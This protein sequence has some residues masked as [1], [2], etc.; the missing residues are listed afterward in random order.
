MPL[1]IPRHRRLVDPD[2]CRNIDLDLTLSMHDLTPGQGQASPLGLGEH[3]FRLVVLPKAELAACTYRPYALTTSLRH[4]YF[5][6]RFGAYGDQ[7]QLYS[8]E[9]ASQFDQS[10]KGRRFVKMQ[11]AYYDSKGSAR[12]VLRVGAVEA[13]RPG[14]GEVRVRLSLSGVNPTDWRMRSAGD[15]P[16][17][18]Q[19]PG[20]DGAGWIESV[21][22]GVDAS[23][24]GDRVWVFHAAYGSPHGTV[25]ELT[26]I[27]AEQ[28]IVLPD[29]VSFEQG[30]GLGIPYITAHRCL[31]DDGP[32]DGQ[33]VLVTG[34]AGAVGNAAIALGTWL[35]ATMI[36]TVSSSAKAELARAAGASRVLHYQSKDFGD[37]LRQLAPVSRIIDVAIGANMDAS[38]EILADR[39]VLVSYASEDRDPAIPV[40][41]LM[42][43]NVALEFVMVYGST[44]TQLTSAIGE[45]TAFVTGGGKSVLPTHVFPLKSVADAHEAVEGGVVGKVLIQLPE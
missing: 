26:C 10:R 28:A 13:P 42:T 32:V 11:A 37:D 41:R 9:W 44:P 8:R 1:N 12:D 22:E 43:K 2:R 35:G 39:G 23:R 24:V 17:T 16:F 18:R 6:R 5:C 29:G 45:I 33:R 19:V 20:Q 7:T 27:P 14:P 31:M 30:A 21:G 38:L 36:A 40:R 3:S 34:G 4:Q 15:M 25:A